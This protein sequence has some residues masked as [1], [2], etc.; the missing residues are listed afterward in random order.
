MIY[1]KAI[2]QR[3]AR[4]YA[5][6]PQASPPYSGILWVDTVA[7]TD[8]DLTVDAT[9][10]DVDNLYSDRFLCVLQSDPT[11]NGI[12]VNGSTLGDGRVRVGEIV[13][14]R[15]GTVY[16][17]TAWQAR[18]VELNSDYSRVDARFALLT[19]LCINFAANATLAPHA[20]LAV[21]D[22]VPL[23]LFLPDPTRTFGR[24]TIKDATGSCDGAHP[25]TINPGIYPIDGVGGNRTITSAYGSISIESCGSAWYIV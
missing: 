5:P 20:M 3:R 15:R 7:V 1:N 19:P 25:I 6:Q 18:S 11:E 22:T 14:V 23:V 2:Q 13:M 21:A 12:N 9:I 10:D 4:E 8:V 16:A 17:G 24:M